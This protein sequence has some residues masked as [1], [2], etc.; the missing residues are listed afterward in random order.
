MVKTFLAR[1]VPQKYET[2]NATKWRFSVILWR[3]SN[4]FNN[5]QASGAYSHSTV[6][7]G[8]EVIS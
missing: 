6:A 4:Y 2:N 7:G 3:F 1:I 8:L 5:Q